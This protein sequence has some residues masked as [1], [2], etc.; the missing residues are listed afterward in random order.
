MKTLPKARSF[1]IAVQKSGN[2]LLIKDLAAGRI[3][4]LNETAAA[5]YQACDGLTAISELGSRHQLSRATIV[6]VLN[7]LKQRHLITEDF[8]FPLPVQQIRRREALK[9]FGLA[10]IIGALGNILTGCG[11]NTDITMPVI[12]GGSVTGGTGSSSSTGTAAVGAT[13]YVIIT[14]ISSRGN[15]DNADNTAACQAL[16]LT[17]CQSRKATFVCTGPFN[18]SCACTCL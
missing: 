13:G 1:N 2:D 4:Q 18:N 16:A 9:L 6:A 17:T 3:Y 14:Y 5:V 15:A 12:Q 8:V 7:E 10:G 11:G